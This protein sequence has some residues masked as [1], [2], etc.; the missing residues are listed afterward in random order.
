[1]QGMI[2]EKQGVEMTEQKLRNIFDYQRF[3]NNDRL[4]AMLT[5]ALGRYDFSGEGELSDDEVGL[6]NAAGTTA[7]DPKTDRGK[8]I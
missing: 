5:D 6:L 1:M 2:I 3:E 7:S 8:R 4:S